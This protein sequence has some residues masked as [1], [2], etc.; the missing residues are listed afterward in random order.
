MFDLWVQW[1][2]H[3]FAQAWSRYASTSGHTTSNC[4][5]QK[6][7]ADWV[8][9]NYSSKFK[10]YQMYDLAKRIFHYLSDD[11]KI[12][13]EWEEYF[14]EYSDFQ[15]E[16]TTSLAT[17]QNLHVFG[18]L[19]ANALATSYPVAILGAVFMEGSRYLA[20]R[21]QHLDHWKLFFLVRSYAVTSHQS[22]KQP[23]HHETIITVPVSSLASISLRRILLCSYNL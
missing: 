4:N 11:L 23:K 6:V 19:C 21:L 14:G 7:M 9:T 2:M 15:A 10:T 1:S 16:N 12:L 8:K 3:C 22:A 5:W 18:R 13:K 17:L 20:T